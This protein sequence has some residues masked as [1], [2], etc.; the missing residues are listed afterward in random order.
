MFAFV[1]LVHFVLHGFF[2]SQMSPLKERTL[3][4]CTNG[5]SWSVCT[6][7]QLPARWEFRNG[8]YFRLANVRAI[9]SSY[10]HAHR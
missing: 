3:C 1:R 5:S 2:R 6:S 9:T 10:T 4:V 7:G 8:A